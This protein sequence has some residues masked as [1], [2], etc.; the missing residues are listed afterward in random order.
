[1]RDETLR[2]RRGTSRRRHDRHGMASRHDPRQRARSLQP[3]GTPGLPNPYTDRAI[4]RRGTRAA[5]ADTARERR[6]AFARGAAAR[7]GG[8]GAGRAG[9]RKLTPRR[10]SAGTGRMGTE[11]ALVF[12]IANEKVYIRRVELMGLGKQT[13][14]AITIDVV[15]G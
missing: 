2:N 12:A 1:R 7:P 9:T 11:L 4:A 3:D 5:A 14:R 15:A 10:S 8:R 6:T 13:R